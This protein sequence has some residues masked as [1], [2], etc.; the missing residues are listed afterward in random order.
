MN[1]TAPNLLGE[2]TAAPG[3]AITDLPPA[4]SLSPMQMAYNLVASGADFASVREMLDYAKALEREA[5]EMAFNEAMSAAQKEI[6]V[7]AANMTNT[8]TK[9]RYADYAQLDRA[10][11]PVYSKH[12]FALSFDEEEIAKPEYVRIVCY[13]SHTAGHTRKYHRDMPADGKGARGGDVMTKTHAAGAAGSYAMR[14]LVRGIFNVA[15]GEDDRDGNSPAGDGEPISAE[16]LAI[17]RGLIDETGSDIERFCR[18]FK[19]DALPDLPATQFDR[20]L[21]SLNAKRAK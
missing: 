16:Q 12:G 6:S 17:V 4:Q 21:A 5:A 9:S 15:V 14:Y 18:Y 10:L 13:V 20:A 1:A 3:T 19:I 7:V 8:Q 11:R 2:T